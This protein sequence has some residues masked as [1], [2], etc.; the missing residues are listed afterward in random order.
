MMRQSHK[1]TERL[2][3]LASMSHDDAIKSMMD[4]RDGAEKCWCHSCKHNVIFSV[5]GI[6]MWICDLCRMD[7]TPN[8]KQMV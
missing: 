3:R 2:K 8:P 4:E 5:N 1:A 7:I 6:G